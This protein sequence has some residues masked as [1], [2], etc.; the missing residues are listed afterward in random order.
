MH[1]AHALLRGWMTDAGAASV[2]IDPAGNLR[3]RWEPAGNGRVQTFVIGS[4][5]DT[6][7]NAGRYDGM[8]GVLIGIAAMEQTHRAGTRLPF[9]VEVI[10]FSEEEGVRFKTPYLGSRAVAGTFDPP[11]LL[12]QDEH[13][14]TVAD[15]I[16]A[17]GLDPTRLA[18]AAFVPDSLTGYI[19]VHIEQ[20]PVLEAANLPLAVVEAIVG[21]SRLSLRLTGSAGH[22]GTCPMPARRDASPERRKSY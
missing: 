5:L 2:R 16:R 13:G 10:G 19:E 1:Q 12:L 22:A 11:L 9:A 21:Q 4:H 20:G 6:V 3:G 18:D 8:L 17:F 7:N 15:A 14:E